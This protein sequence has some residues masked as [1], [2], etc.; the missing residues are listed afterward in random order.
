MLAV[1]VASFERRRGR[2]DEGDLEPCRLQR[3]PRRA[4]ASPAGTVRYAIASPTGA[5]ARAA[6]AP[7]AGG[8][9]ILEQNDAGACGIACHLEMLRA[10]N[11]PCPECVPPC[12]LM[13]FEWVEE[14]NTHLHAE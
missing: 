5:L 7:P 14:A 13:R 11:V 9:G 6:V 1:A 2:S 8:V 10:A 3:Q 12:K 4:I